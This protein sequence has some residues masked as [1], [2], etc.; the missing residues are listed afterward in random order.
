[1]QYFFYPINQNT[2]GKTKQLLYFKFNLF[3]IFITSVVTV[4]THGMDNKS[5][6]L[7][8]IQLEVSQWTFHT[9]LEAEPR[10]STK[11]IILE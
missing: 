9:Y 7:L 6:K 2:L 11:I 3:Q 10:V 5:I 1:M 8:P 4:L